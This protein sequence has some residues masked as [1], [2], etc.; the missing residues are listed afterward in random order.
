MRVVFD[1]FQSYIME[2]LQPAL[3]PIPISSPSS[4]QPPP[5]MRDE[6]EPVSQHNLDALL[7]AINNNNTTNNTTTDSARS[8]NFVVESQPQNAM[9]IQSL[10]AGSDSTAQQQL[11]NN[12]VKLL[13][14]IKLRA[15]TCLN[16]IFFYRTKGNE[17]WKK[18]MI[19]IREQRYARQSGI[20]WLW[21]IPESCL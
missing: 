15:V 10:L 19:T 4:A 1:T 11:H 3:I 7:T 9:S 18:R 6:D 8:D 21:T 13:S 12:H 14:P 2:T 17:S 5:S 16:L 20:T